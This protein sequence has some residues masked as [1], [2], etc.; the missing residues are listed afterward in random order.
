M[1]EQ[2]ARI[3]LLRR[4][5][6]HG[7]NTARYNLYYGDGR[8]S[9]DT[10]GRTAHEAVFN[11]TS[12]V[13]RCPNSQQGFSP[14]TTWTRG[15]AWALCGFAEQL[16]FLESFP[17][18]NSMMPPV[19]CPGPR[20][21]KAPPRATP[22]SPPS[23]EPRTPTAEFYLENTCTD[24]IPMWDTGA[25]HLHRLGR[26]LDKPSTRTTPGNP[27]IA[28]PPPSP[29]RGFSDSPDMVRFLIHLKLAPPLNATAKP[30]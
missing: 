10:S 26:Y 8:D 1:G 27:S 29:P 16:E 7:L 19:I 5:L 6:E 17:P 30:D 14:F 25:P 4:A 20:S 23:A 3:S 24:G 22:V 12:G 13:F 21:P 11:T 18:P 9:Y 28:P 15:L 2:D